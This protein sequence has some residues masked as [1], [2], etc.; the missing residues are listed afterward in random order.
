MKIHLGEA[1]L[2]CGEND[3]RAYEQIDGRTGAC[4]EQV[5]S[6]NI[7]YYFNLFLCKDINITV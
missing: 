7:L 1:A 5:K 6:P 4:V 2:I 3:R